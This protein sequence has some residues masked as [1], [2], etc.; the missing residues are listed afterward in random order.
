MVLYINS[1]AEVKADAHIIC[2]SSNT[3]SAIEACPGD[4]VLMAPDKNL[5]YN[6]QPKTSKTLIP[7][8]G[9]CPVHQLMTR[10]VLEY[11]IERYPNAEIVVHP[12]CNPDVTELAHVVLST[13]GMVDHVRDSDRNEFIIGTE[14]GLVQ[15]LIDMFPDKTFHGLSS[16][17]KTCD[18]MCSCPYMKA[19]TIGKI[20]RALETNTHEIE[21][22]DDIREKS[23]VAIERMINIGRDQ[24]PR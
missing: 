13:S 14:E 23:L 24:S 8:E 19:V 15:M 5:Y 10:D 4:T 6:F 18:E 9:Y 12:E 7:W 1:S 11:A 2:T 3:L 17:K 21:V 22:P 16:E 20:R